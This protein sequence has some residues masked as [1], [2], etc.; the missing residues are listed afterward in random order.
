MS[1][2]AEP[3]SRR[4]GPPSRAAAAEA[5]ARPPPRL[6]VGNPYSMFVGLMKVVLPA[7]AA[8]LILLVIAWPK[9]MLEDDRFRAGVALLT[10]DQV[11]NLSMLN[12]RFEGIDEKSQPY[13]ITAN[14]AT[15]SGVAEDLVDLDLPKADIT[16][17]DGAWLALTARTGQ[18][19]REGKL[20]DLH[21]SVSLFHDKGF[22]LRSEF[23]RIDLAGATAEGDRP[24]EGQG[25]LGHINAEGFRM[26]DRGERIIF[27]GK[28][29][30]VIFPEAEEHI[31]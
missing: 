26:L 13:T 10:P 14:M 21:G 3:V 24:V 27:T 1:Q 28:S 29:R 8:A 22:E 23:A 25:T 7:M 4:P 12:A 9:L 30:L 20:L 11:D 19:R 17:E 16:L 6:S 31:R 18:Y 15:Q 2:I 5:P